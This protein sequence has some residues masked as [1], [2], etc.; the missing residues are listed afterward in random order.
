MGFNPP[1]SNIAIH[2]LVVD[3][4]EPSQLSAGVKRG[5]CF[6]YLHRLA[7]WLHVLTLETEYK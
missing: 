3:D 5:E 1:V 7:A 4:V 2:S 6:V